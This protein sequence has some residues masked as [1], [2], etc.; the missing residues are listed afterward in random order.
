MKKSGTTQRPSFLIVPLKFYNW[1]PE[2]F[3]LLIHFDSTLHF[4]HHNASHLLL[5]SA[6]ISGAEVA[7]FSLLKRI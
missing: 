7:L 1:T 5:A 4:W 6:L 3:S 2:P